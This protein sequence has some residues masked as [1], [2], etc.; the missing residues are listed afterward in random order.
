M[1]PIRKNVALLFFII[2][3]PVFCQVDIPVFGQQQLINGY[4]NAISGESLPYFSIY[5]D[6]VKEALLTRCTDGVKKIEWESAGIPENT[7]GPYAYFS[8]I[9]A[10]STGTSKGIRNFDLYIN[11]EFI[12]TFTTSPKN[13][14]PHWSFTG[15]DSSKLVFEFKTKDAANDAHGIAYLRIPVSKYKKGKPLRL[16][17]VGQNQNSSDWYMTFKYS[18]EEKIDIEALPFIVK[19]K[20][21]NQQALLFTVLHFGGPEKLEVHVKGGLNR[22]FLLNNGLNPI[23]LLMDAVTSET[24]IYIQASIGKVFT[25]NRN[26]VLQPVQQREIHLIHHSHTDIGY[27]N[28]QE[29]VIEI[30][31]NNIRRALY[32]I[33]KT[34][35]YPTGSRFVWNVESLWAVENYLGQASEKERK[36]FFAAVKN[37]QIGLSALYA[38]VLTGL[39]TPEEINWISDYAATLKEQYHLPVKTAMMSDIPGISWSMVSALAK[40]NIRYFSNGPN[41]M[42]G[43]PD[44]GDR[45]G[46]ILKELGDKPCWW[47]SG[48]GKDSILL[49]TGAKGYS[50]WHGFREG[51]MKERGQ[52]KIAAYLNELDAKAYPYSMV[53]WRYNI[54]SDNGPVDSTICD[55]VKTWNEKYVSPKLYLSNVNDLFEAFEKKYGATIPVLSGDLTPYWEDGAY[56]TAFEETENRLLSEKITQLEKSAK[57]KNK[58]LNKDWLYQAKRNVVLFHEHTWGSW[59]SISE[60]DSPFTIHQW[61]YKKQFLDSGQYYANKIELALFPTVVHPVSIE[62]TNTLDWNRNGYVE[63][64]WPATFTGNVLRDDKGNKITVQKLANNKMGFV[65]MNVPANGTITYEFTPEKNNAPPSFQ[66][67]YTYTTDKNTGAINQLNVLG[68]EWVSAT[69]YKGLNQAV[70]VKGLN[71]DSFFLSRL[72]SMEWIEE[73]PFVKK[74]SIS[75]ELEGMKEILYEITQFKDLDYIQ[76]SVIMDKKAIREKEA[77]HIAFPFSIDH[78]VVRIDCDNT[79]ISPEN[80]QITGSNKDFFSVQRWIDI[81]GDENGVT[82]SSPQ[83]ALFETGNM[84]DEQTTNKGKKLWKSEN[85]SSATIFLYAMNNYW[86]TNYK[87]DQEGKVKFDCVLQFHTAFEIKQAQQTGME[88]T[89]P[90]LIHLK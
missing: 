67:S 9:A 75:C 89:Q 37:N 32:L 86:H 39:C 55:F 16:K 80:G 20:T 79:F 6:Y 76:V 43:L 45:I 52:K 51:G 68:K 1:N 29:E 90:M 57:Q 88:T 19:G 44:G 77:V 22:S 24:T 13:Y 47:K 27:S 3:T 66:S 69:A 78:P 5:P 53:Q 36:D 41:Y 46:G 48:S 54:G 26:I 84:I 56:S 31:T 14:P 62:L 50:S 28:I 85:K 70:Y 25:V 59:N 12:L 83:G 10:H 65:A 60:P 63:S 58:A 17:V 82:I 30:H 81:S 61:N 42:E 40:K 49:W 8:W 71:P 73:G 4:V 15:K 11:D 23:E 7:K 35:N 33:E 87:A 18:F 2:S 21:N 34:K 74:Q 72:K 64:E 38:N